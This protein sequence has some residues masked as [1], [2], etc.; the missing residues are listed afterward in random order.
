[1]FLRG[2][3]WRYTFGVLRA[4]N[5]LKQYSHPLAVILFFLMKNA[6]TLS[7]AFIPNLTID[8]AQ[9]HYTA[10]IEGRET[11]VAER[12]DSMGIIYYKNLWGAGFTF[13]KSY[14]LLGTVP[15][16]L[17]FNFPDVNISA[18]K[19]EAYAD[20]LFKPGFKQ[21]KR[22]PTLAEPSAWSLQLSVISDIKIDRIVT[23]HSTSFTTANKFAKSTAINYI[24][25]TKI[26]KTDMGGNKLRY[27][28]WVEFESDLYR[29]NSHAKEFYFTRVEGGKA[30]IFVDVRKYWRDID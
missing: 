7:A 17:S 25:I 16:F 12:S 14:K 27:H 9:V 15:C 2:Y 28:L 10:R 26:Q 20:S 30:K 18:N 24:R 6:L 23:A 3:F 19:Q 22:E 5:R 1:M 8:T 29:M 21:L 4:K 11:A 13:Y